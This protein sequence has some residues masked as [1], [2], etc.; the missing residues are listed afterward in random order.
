MPPRR[1]QLLG[2]QPGAGRRI[3]IPPCFSVSIPNQ[4]PGV[5]VALADNVTLAG[6]G[7]ITLDASGTDSIFTPHF[8]DTFTIGAGQTIS[9]SGEIGNGQ[10]TIVNNG[11]LIATQANPLQIIGSGAVTFTNNGTLREAGG[12]LQLLDLNVMG[13]TLAAAGDQVHEI[14]RASCRE[15]V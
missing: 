3:E 11:A 9:G 8:G 12:E 6:T 10:T 4:T 13:G 2:C 7:T 5:G 15:R 14:G 1:L